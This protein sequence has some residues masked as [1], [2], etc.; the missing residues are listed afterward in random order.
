MRSGVRPIT[1]RRDLGQSA[2][3]VLGDKA[4]RIDA[5]SYKPQ[6]RRS[7][8]GESVER[9]VPRSDLGLAGAAFLL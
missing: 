6:R 9:D 8:L 7:R 5:P 1:G 2:N 3:S 4:L